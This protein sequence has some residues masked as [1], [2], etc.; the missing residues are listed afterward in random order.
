MIDPQMVT[1]QVR[2]AIE[3]SGLSRYRISKDT[4]IDQSTISRFC[5]NE[6]GMTLKT[7][8]RLC[9]YLRLRVV[10]AGDR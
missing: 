1:D 4:G 5:R 6:G 2:Q 10:A 3:E 7:F 8:D 9:F